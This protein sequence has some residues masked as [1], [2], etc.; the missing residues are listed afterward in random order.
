[1]L[2]DDVIPDINLRVDDHPDPLPEL[3]RLLAIWRRDSEPRRR[4]FPTLANPSGV[5]D[6]DA[7]EAA[8]REKGLD[9]KFRR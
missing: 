9:L 3:A 5:T 2:S 7:I 6:L 4:W 1:V 8:W